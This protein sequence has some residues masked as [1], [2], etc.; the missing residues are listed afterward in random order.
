VDIDR[1]HAAKMGLNQREIVQNVITALTSNQMIAP[2]YCGQR[3]GND[4]MPTVQYS[5]N[6]IRGLLDLSAIPW[7]SFRLRIPPG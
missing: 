6:Q 3:T 5:E 4:Y 7:L 2:S 1:T